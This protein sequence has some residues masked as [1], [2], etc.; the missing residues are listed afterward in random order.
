MRIYLRDVFEAKYR[1]KCGSYFK[2]RSKNIDFKEVIFDDCCTNFGALLLEWNKLDDPDWDIVC[3][4][5]G[6]L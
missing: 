2:I 1:C 3:E 4:V 5:Y 6:L